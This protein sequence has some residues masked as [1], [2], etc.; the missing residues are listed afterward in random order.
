[1]EEDKAFDI[2]E[3]V[4]RNEHFAAT[5]FIDAFLDPTLLKI[6]MNDLG[7]NKTDW[8]LDGTLLDTAISDTLYDIDPATML[9]SKCKIIK[10]K[11][12]RVILKFKRSARVKLEMFNIYSMGDNDKKEYILESLKEPSVTQAE[13]FV[14]KVVN[15]LVKEYEEYMQGV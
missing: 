14:K 13:A 15:T 11:V 1:V 4:V 12:H 9:D 10:K 6:K 5:Y 8:T 7:L 3:F 2:G